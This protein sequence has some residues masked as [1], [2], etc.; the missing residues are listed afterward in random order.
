MTLRFLVS[1]ATFGMAQENLP[2]VKSPGHC[3]EGIS[4]LI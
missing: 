2:A 3:S 4:L 1:K